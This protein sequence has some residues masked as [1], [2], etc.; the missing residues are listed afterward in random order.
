M[1]PPSFY[2]FSQKDKSFPKTTTPNCLL[3]QPFILEQIDT[4]SLNGHKLVI[5]HPIS[6]NYRW[7]W[8]RKSSS[9]QWAYYHYSNNNRLGV[10]NEHLATKK[11]RNQKIN[12]H[13]GKGQKSIF[14]K[15]RPVND[16]LLLGFC[17]IEPRRYKNQREAMSYVTFDLAISS[18]T[19]AKAFKSN[20]TI[21][22]GNSIIVEIREM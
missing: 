22:W 1:K 6:K 12:H 3:Q 20:K 16:F 10:I 18:A 13:L 9:L 2:L 14:F 7:F 4:L 15:K 17:F 21:S 8:I 19:S 5:F 11:I